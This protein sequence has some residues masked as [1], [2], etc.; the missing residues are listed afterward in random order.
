MKKII[1]SIASL[2][3]FPLMVDAQLN[4]NI[5]IQN[6]PINITKSLPSYKIGVPNTNSEKPQRICA[7]PIL[8]DEYE[9]WV[10]NIIAKNQQFANGKTTAV[11]Y[12]IPVV[13]HIIHNG[14]AIGTTRNISQAQVNS[15]VTVLNNDYRKTNADFNT[16]VTQPS[17]IAAAA[18]CEI[19]FCP[20]LVSP[21]GSVLT[22]P[23][24]E[25][26]NTTT[27]GW[28][29]PPYSGFN[30]SYIEQTIKPGSSW[31]PSKY[32]NIWVLEMND[33]VLGYAQFPT[34]PSPLTPTIGDMFNQGGAANT[35][36][37]VFDYR[38]VGT[39]GSATAPYNLGRTA[40]HEIGHWLGLRHP[41]GDTTCGDDNVSDTPA[42]S[43]LSSSCP[44]TA[45]AVVASGCT[46]SPN[47]P[48]RN[49]Q[50]YMDY[51]DDACLTMFTSG[52]KARMQACMANCPRRMSLNT[53][54]VCSLPN[55]ID[56]KLFIADFSIFPNPTN[57]EIRVAVTVNIPQ[58][59]S[60]TIVNTLGQT[61]KEIKQNQASSGIHKID[62]SNNITG[63]Y[64]I[65]VKSA[66]YSKTKRFV[67]Q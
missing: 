17:F 3:V 51:T 60:I 47:P 22:E 20:A 10:Q 24:I 57:G 25:R 29:A 66:N 56:E 8:N 45:G 65:N 32:L 11:I 41:N 44:S 33:G 36:G 9:N 64:F 67:L 28:T 14:Q 46:V 42:Q 12:T 58:D 39:V 18:D 5:L 63:I 40:S 30:S 49:Y 61:I 7:T 48:G 37:V 55:S 2:L 27:K 38:Y 34:V 53:S 23:G 43:N 31:D 6:V 16:W 35:D 62:I 1:L 19:N 21:T 15:Q 54:N 4:S 59:Y 13:F 50:N 52:Q 26:I